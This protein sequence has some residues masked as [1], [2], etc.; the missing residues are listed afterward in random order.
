[1]AP[2]RLKKDTRT[3]NSL[4]IG[5]VERSVAP[6]TD[7]IIQLNSISKKYQMGEVV[8]T[9]LDRVCLSIQRGDFVAIMGPSGSGKSTL[10]HVLGLLDPVE[11]G[12]Y[13]LEGNETS[14]LKENELSELRSRTIGFIFQQFNLLPRTSALENVGLPIL[15]QTGPERRSPA[16]LLK[17]VGLEGR[18]AHH[19]NELSG[20]QQQ[21]VAIAR[22]LVNEPSILLADEPT[23]NLDSTSEEE[24]LAILH[25]LNEQGITVIVVTHEEKIAQEAKRV[26]RMRDG[27]ISSDIRT[28]PCPSSNSRIKSLPEEAAKSKV[29]RFIQSA[30]AHC[31]QAYKALASNKVRS[32]LSMLGILIGVAAVIAMLAIGQGAKDSI[33]KSLSSLGSNLL[34]LMPGSM[35]S[36]GVALEAG[37]VT[38]FTMEDARDIGDSVP[39]VKHTSPSVSGR[40]QAVFGN[41]NWNTSVTGTLPEYAS[42]HNA[43]AQ[44]GRYF[45]NDENLE[46]ARVALLGTTTV[47]ELFGGANPIGEYVKLNK[48]SF[49]I[50][51]VLKKKGAQGFRDEDDVIVIPLNT[52]MHR[53][54][55]KDFVD[56]IDIEV[57]DQTK[58]DQVETQTHDL[59]VRR[60]RLPPSQVD[61]FDVRNMAEIQQAFSSTS[62][63][64]SGL[65]ACIAA[66][67]LLVGGIGIMNIMLVSVTERTREIGLR[68][69][70]GA[71][72]SDILLQFLVEAMIVSALGGVIGVALGLSIAFVLT[73]IAGWAAPVSMASIFLSLLFS[74][75]IGIIFGLWPA[76][77]ASA[78]SPISALRYE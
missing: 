15:Y 53:L 17:E 33:E 29:Q 69:A 43:P 74:A 10:L 57:S 66:I 46:R 12:S 26:I 8:V 37:T 2:D 34:V 61:S 48:V 16:V 1:M 47:R 21:R 3:E 38:R 23:G 72:P 6:Q 42:L 64:L 63:V 56:Q 78:L 36:M 39:F 22:A 68:K 41:K 75:G 49:Q 65:L 30:Y 71:K 55:G 9:A 67:S 54:L 7:T 70:V 62:R 28:S 59:I 4:P 51:G 35:R 25:K 14:H 31:K 20:G 13:S 77:K 27:V 24:I 18:L 73:K 19:P 44:V 45:S 60:H 32:G 11:S 52:A 40:V 76:K 50:I 58:M 5:S